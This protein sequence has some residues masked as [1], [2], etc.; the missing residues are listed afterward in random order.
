VLVASIPDLYRL[1]QALEG[2]IR[3]ELTWRVAHICQSMLAYPGT[4]ADRLAVAAQ[5]QA[6]NGAL[7]AVC[8]RFS[9]CRDDAGAVYQERFTAAQVSTVDFFHPSVAGQQALAAVTWT[10]GFWPSTR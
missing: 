2:N 8:A 1:W 5:E 6:D 3:A 10:A 7:V 9:H 4:G